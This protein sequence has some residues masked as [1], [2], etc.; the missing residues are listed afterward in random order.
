MAKPSPH[1]LGIDPK[2][3]RH[4]TMATLA[5]AVVVGV[6]ANGDAQ[7][8]VIENEKRL[9][10]KKADEQMFGKTKLVDNRDEAVKQSAASA[11]FAP[12]PGPIMD[13]GGNSIGGN[14]Y[15]PSDLGQ[16][17]MP[18]I[19]APNEAAM[20]RMTAD[21]RNAYLKAL[22]DDAKKRAAKGP[23]VPTQAQRAAIEAA[24]AERAGP[25]GTDI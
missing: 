5:I 1:L 13:M 25:A 21:G 12:D 20:A 14:S 4:F 16:P 19:I 24:S 10:I 6:F 8:S 9:E 15:V 23:Y 11:D 3:Y 2:L 22:Q 17:R 7:R 18:V